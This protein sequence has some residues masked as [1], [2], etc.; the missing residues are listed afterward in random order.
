MSKK[1]II[2]INCDMGESFGIYKLGMDD[3]IIEYVT[4]A[5]IACGFHAG[6]HNVMK[7]TVE[8]AINSETGIGAH[9][10]F[11]DMPG[12]GRRKMDIKGEEL[13]NLLVYQIG[14][15]SAFAKARGKKLQHVK[16]H[17]A[18]YNMASS[19]YEMAKI[20]AE[21]VKNVNNNLILVALG[22]STLYKAA[23]DIGLRVAFEAF[24]DRVYADDGTLASRSK[25][26]AVIENSGEISRR[27][28][29]MIKEGRAETITGNVIEMEPDT[30]CVHGDNPEAL[31]IV[32]DL[33]KNLHNAGIN[34]LP[35]GEF[36]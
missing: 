33:V 16:P 22:G 34:I 15:L 9:P 2:D 35:M 30:I 27:V 28:V 20:V 19:N 25:E 13:K 7:D 5:N 26:G 10:G 23:E 8:I 11:P 1:G 21:S 31:K 36:L 3:K 14:A 24:A 32:K 4:S 17:G 6:D 18:L 12:F 29:R